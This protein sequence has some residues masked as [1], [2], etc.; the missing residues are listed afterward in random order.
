MKNKLYMISAAILGLSI[1]LCACGKKESPT[2][3]TAKETAT[4][5]AVTKMSATKSETETVTFVDESGYHV[6]S[7]I[8][9]P[10]EKATIPTV[11][12]RTQEPTYKT[13]T[14]SHNQS[15]TKADAPQNASKPTQ[16]ISTTQ[17]QNAITTQPVTVSEITNGLNLLFKT[18]TVNRGND[19]TITISGDSGKEYSI[20]VYRNNSDKLVSDSLNAKNADANGFVSW[21]FDT[22]N[23]ESGYR[24]IVIREINGNKYIQTSIKIN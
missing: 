15:A 9:Q 17:V 12:T 18:D 7:I 11:P 6:V 24:K 3:T 23:C 13:E 2:Q 22:D 21:T 14:L 1:I 20:E 19:A 4:T 8:V 10:T 5:S 16:A